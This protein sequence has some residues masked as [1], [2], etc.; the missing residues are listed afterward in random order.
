M[1]HFGFIY[2]VILFN[3]IPVDLFKKPF[4]IHNSLI[5]TD[6]DSVYLTLS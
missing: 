6:K 3:I 4:T 1:E 2:S 5:T